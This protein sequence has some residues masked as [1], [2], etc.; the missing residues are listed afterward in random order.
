MS[1]RYAPVA[2][3]AVLLGACSETSTSS[4]SSS[5]S[6]GEASTGSSSSGGGS[7]SSSSSGA[8]S[9]SSGDAGDLGDAGDVNGCATFKDETDADAAQ[10]VAIVWD[11]GLAKSAMRCIKVKVG[12]SVSFKGDFGAHPIASL[13]GD[14]PT[15]FADAQDNVMNPG[16]TEER[17][18]VEFK[19]AG[20]FG[21]YC[22]FHRTMKGAVQVVP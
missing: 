22:T 17:T 15:P 20:T 11:F 8:A 21:Y 19:T 4:T 12:T 2:F 5:S 7:T 16:T 6:S 13:G 10:S 1:F 18:T 14:T 3:I 9:S